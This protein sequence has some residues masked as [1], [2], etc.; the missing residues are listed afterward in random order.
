M[1]RRSLATLVAAFV[2]LSTGILAAN[3]APSPASPAVAAASRHASALAAWQRLGADS[4]GTWSVTADPLHGVVKTLS[5]GLTAPMGATPEAAAARF[6]AAYRPLTGIDPTRLGAP[7]VVDRPSIS[8]VTYPVL[9]AGVPVDGGDVA[10]AMTPRGEVALLQT[11]WAGIATPSAKATLSAR[12]AAEMARKAVLRLGRTLDR[13]SATL[14]V[15]PP[16]GPSGRAR[17]AYRVT[18]LLTVHPVG[19]WVVYVDAATGAVTRI[20]DDLRTFDTRP[21]LPLN[22][23]RTSLGDSAHGRTLA[24]VARRPAVDALTLFNSFEGPTLGAGWIAGHGQNAQAGSPTWGLQNV[25]SWGGD[26]SAWCAGSGGFSPNTGYANNMDAWMIAGPFSLSS[27]KY[28]QATSLTL[29]FYVWNN[30]E[31]HYDKLF[32]GAGTDGSNFSGFS[33]DGY[34]GGWRRVEFDLTNVPGLG[35]LRGRS[36][37]WVAFEFTSDSSRISNGAFID[38]VRLEA[39]WP[40]AGLTNQVGAWSGGA[41]TAQ[42]FDNNPGGNPFVAFG[43]MRDLRVG[44]NATGSYYAGLEGPWVK[45]DNE[46]GPN[47][48]QE[49]LP[50]PTWSFATASDY[51]RD[52]PTAFQQVNNIHG[53]YSALFGTPAPGLPGRGAAA[54]P[55]DYRMIANVHHRVA[56]ANAFYDPEDGNIYFGDGDGV[57]VRNTV[58]GKDVVYHEYTHAVTDHVASLPY[59]LETGAMSEAYSDYFAGSYTNDPSLGEWVLVNDARD[60]AQD[61]GA[62]QLPHEMRYDNQ[63]QW[64]DGTVGTQP[65]ADWW[66]VITPTSHNDNGWVHHNSLIYSG[67]LWDVRGALGA[68]TADRA[69]FEGLFF[70]PQSVAEGMYSILYADDMV[71]G[72][73]IFSNGTPHEAQIRQ[74]FAKHGMQQDPSSLD[75]VSGTTATSVYGHGAKVAADLN[76]SANVGTHVRQP[77]PNAVVD[78]CASPIGQSDYVKIRS[79][80]TNG[81]GRVVGVV[82][83]TKNSSVVLYYRGDVSTHSETYSRLV[84]V[85]VVPVP[86]IGYSGTSR[87]VRFYGRINPTSAHKRHIV[88]I[89]RKIGSRYYKL[90]SGRTNNSGVYSIVVAWR[91]FRVGSIYRVSAFVA[92]DAD[93]LA[94]RSVTRR[95]RVT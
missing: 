76:N 62:G 9:V 18:G 58:R 69:I 50:L 5:G 72:D 20:Y 21:L 7:R 32:W 15:V 27:A 46:A 91:K 60:L 13:G 4:R 92:A 83:P 86:T 17:Y 37:A 85:Y 41:V 44:G 38:N 55:M 1:R 64:E 3:A 73:K 14:V 87:G 47:L 51:E 52:Q 42:Y 57:N 81:A 71:Y 28:S 8:H 10:V 36:Q 45:A 6:L 59:Q 56:Y 84:T 2:I 33:I 94:G 12:A 35:D 54:N 22:P 77:I 80:T 88:S 74:A 11:H 24:A 68:A 26:M 48:T 31:P 95:F 25:N 43:G 29:S 70:N 66:T 65:T 79:A 53:Y 23:A 67:A 61:G 78:F 40:Q 89:Q 16:K 39:S 19:Q 34:T 82:N 49:P 75:L 30:S 90:G 63:A 93:H